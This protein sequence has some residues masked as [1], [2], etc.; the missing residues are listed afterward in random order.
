MATASCDNI[1]NSDTG[2]FQSPNY[3]NKY[4]PGE[5]HYNINVTQGQVVILNW[6]SFDIGQDKKNGKCP[7]DSVWI[8]DGT[9]QTY[10]GIFILC[11]QNKQSITSSAHTLTIVFKSKTHGMFSGF[12]ATYT[13][14]KLNLKTSR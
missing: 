5:C 14:G 9:V 11:G 10:N 3:P 12:S 8:Y 6:K 1:L 4:G 13:T 2:S 7:G